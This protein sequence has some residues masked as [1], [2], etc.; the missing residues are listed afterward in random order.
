MGL[1]G[2]SVSSLLIILVIVLLLFG[3]KRLRSIGSDLGGALKGFREAMREGES[4]ESELNERL[5]KSESTQS[6][7][8]AEEADK[9]TNERQS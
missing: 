9:Q 7:T 2:V 4:A 8:S 1:G 3:T 6:R 5:E